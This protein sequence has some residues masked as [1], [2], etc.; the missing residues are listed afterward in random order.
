VS[1]TWG[2][3]CDNRL[4]QVKWRVEK[5]LNVVLRD[6]SVDELKMRIGVAGSTRKT[7]VGSFCVWRPFRMKVGR[8]GFGQRENDAP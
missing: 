8:M 5:S 1:R 6:L 4:D 7:G 2:D 3:N